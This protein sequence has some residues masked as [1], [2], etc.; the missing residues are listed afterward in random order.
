MGAEPISKI[1]LEGPKEDLDLTENT[2]PAI[3][4]VSY[5]IFSVLKKEYNFDFNSTKFF[6][7]HSLG[8]Y[9]ALVCA[10]SLEFNDALFLLFERGK[11][12]QEAVPVGKGSM[13]AVL[14]SKIDELNNLIKEV[15]I[16]GVCEIANDNCDG[17]VV[18][19]GQ[20]V[21][22]EVLQQKLKENKRKPIT[23]IRRGF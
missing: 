21:S 1:V 9:S 10:D 16:K 11:S 17:Q 5:A 20:K 14:G 15:K 4:T 8:E 7:G 22:I 6:A 12:M 3:L 2:Q 18:V 13:I 23:L 19:S